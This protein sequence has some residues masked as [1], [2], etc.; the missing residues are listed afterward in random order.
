MKLLDR[1]LFSSIIKSSIS[2]LLGLVVLF[3]FFQFL[4][5]LNDVTKKGYT[6]SIAINYIAL[7]LPSF[8]NLLLILGVMIGVVF[9]L[10][11][12]NSNKELQIFQVASISKKDIIS[13]SIK[14]TFFIS[15]MLIIVLEIISPYTS[16]LADQLKKQAQGKPIMSQSGQVW[17]KKDGKFIHHEKNNSDNSIKVF[18][19]ENT[20][21][22]KNIL[23]AKDVKFSDGFVDIVDPRR[24]EIKS[25]GNF[26]IIDN[27]A[28]EELNR[29]ELDPNQLEFLNKN[30]KEMSIFEMFLVIGNSMNAGTNNQELYTEL[31]SRIIK[32]FTLIG[33]I[34]IAIP[35]VL[36]TQRTASVGNRIFISISIAVFAHLITKITSIVL[37]T[38]S[39]TSIVGPFIPTIVLL[40][41]GALVLRVKKQ[42]IY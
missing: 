17:L 29:I 4:E 16:K 9:G 39:S 24:V 15:V 5:E 20:T 2:V 31:I 28:K 14:F 33:M 35:F 19:T 38:K 30:V 13:K 1:Y 42:E 11:Q 27:K 8:F 26:Y 10:G 21:S 23:Y 32:P 36:N 22:L 7:L 41:I 6:I 12:L 25:E 37:V 3:S 34:L 40:L 18:D